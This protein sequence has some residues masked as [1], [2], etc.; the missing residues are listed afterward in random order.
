[1][2]QILKIV[3]MIVLIIFNLLTITILIFIAFSDLYDW[4]ILIKMTIFI[5]ILYLVYLLFMSISIIKKNYF[6]NKRT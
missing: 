6:F 5:I 2:K 4:N 3:W 1:M